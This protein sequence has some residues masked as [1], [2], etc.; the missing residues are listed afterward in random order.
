MAA[1]VTYH[2]LRNKSVLITGGASGIG[3]SMVEEFA[4]QD[5]R[6]AFIDVADDA[7]AQL[8]GNLPGRQVR[9]FHCDLRDIKTLRQTVAEIEKDFGGAVDVLVNNAARDDRQNFYDLGPDEW[10]ECLNV[11]LR[12]Q[13]F[14]TQAVSRGMA[15]QGGGSIILFGSTAW[16]SAVPGIVG[17]TTAKAAINGLTRTLARELGEKKIRVN[18]IVPGAILTERQEKLWLTPELDRKFLELQALNFRLR[19]IDVARVALFLASD[20]A[21]GCAG[22]NFVVDAGITLN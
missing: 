3:A 6:V 13:F 19:A 21:R 22:Q 11:N 1:Q 12:H 7:A 4:L 17:Y 8:I 10:D 5:S 2:S 20:E 14:A 9:F 18:C 16:M 15:A